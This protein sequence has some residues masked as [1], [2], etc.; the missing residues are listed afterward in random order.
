MTLPRSFTTGEIGLPS[1][2]VGAFNDFEGT[3][4]VAFLRD[5][6]ATGLAAGFTA[7]VAL[8][9]AGLRVLAAAGFAALDA[10]G[11]ADLGAAFLAAGLTAGF[12]ALAATR[13]AADFFG[14]AGTAGSALV[15]L[16]LVA[17]LPDLLATAFTGFASIA[18]CLA[19]R[20]ASASAKSWAFCS[21]RLF[22]VPEAPRF[23]P[24]A[25]R[26]AATCRRKRSVFLSR[27]VRAR[28]I[29]ERSCTGVSFP[30]ASLS[31]ERKISISVALQI[32]KAWA[33]L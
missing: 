20:R 24:V 32:F 30:T 6:A 23:V 18:V 15:F 4:L 17:L 19:S 12:A 5:L 7:F 26:V 3:G 21:V 27:R 8:A 2:T 31:E 25:A 11:F 13:L 14:F 29:R 16:A 33:L 28:A 1:L 10:A 9:T 22:A